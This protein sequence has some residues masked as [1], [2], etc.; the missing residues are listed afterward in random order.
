M[1][2][3]LIVDVLDHCSYK[4]SYRL[5]YDRI[6][7]WLIF[8]EVFRCNDLIV[9]APL[10]GGG[11]FSVMEIFKFFGKNTQLKPVGHLKYATD[12]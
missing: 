5:L 2:H 8:Y 7:L 4:F 3:W 12:N 6:I 9:K 11:G 10:V 1:N